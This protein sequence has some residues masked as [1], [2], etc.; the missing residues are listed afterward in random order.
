MAGKF[1]RAAAV[2]LAREVQFTSAYEEVPATRSPAL[3]DAVVAQAC[4][5]RFKTVEKREWI[6]LL[7]VTILG[8]EPMIELRIDHPVPELI[9]AEDAPTLRAI[10]EGIAQLDAG[11]GIPLEELRQELARRCSK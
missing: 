6:G 3:H 11:Q 7:A 8:I 1:C 2:A 4:A 10:D 5:P 9:A